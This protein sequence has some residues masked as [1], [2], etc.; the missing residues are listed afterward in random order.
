[1]R[2]ISSRRKKAKAKNEMLLSYE[3]FFHD[4][5]TPLN[6]MFSYMLMMDKLPGIPAEA[7]AYMAEVKKNWYR[8]IKLINDA[9]D[10]T[11]INC[12]TLI[13][14]VKNQDMVALA[15]EMAQATSLLADKKK[16]RLRFCANADEKVMAVDKNMVERILLNLLSNAIKYTPSGGEVSVTVHDLKNKVILTV[17]DNGRGIP[18]DILDRIFERNVRAPGTENQEGSGL[19]LSIVKELAEVMGGE[20]SIKSDSSGTS[21]AVRFP[22]M[23][24]EDPRT[25]EKVADLTADRMVQIELSDQYFAEQE[26]EE[27]YLRQYLGNR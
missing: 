19:G 26:A 2:R 27:Q 14:K 22:V 15:K 23:Y 13:P 21:V 3:N 11:R 25:A 1:M 24:I 17:A 20:V 7:A 18:A 8:V 10:R 16:I 9:S 5:K 4:V 12:G 6:I